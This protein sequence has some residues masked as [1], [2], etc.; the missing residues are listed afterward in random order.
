M[1]AGK[2]ILDSSYLLTLR[3]FSPHTCP[4]PQVL[5][6]HRRFAHGESPLKIYVDSVLSVVKV[7]WLRNISY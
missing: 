1:A 7:L 5:G 4:E 2:D 3:T 6:S